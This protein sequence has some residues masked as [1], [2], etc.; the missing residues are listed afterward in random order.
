M[1]GN[2]KI[3]EF[4]LSSLL[5]R[6]VKNLSIA[7]VL[8]LVISVLASV[9]FLTRS[10]KLE[11]AALLADSPELIV[12]K[13]VGGRH[14]LIPVSRAEAISS[15]TGVGKVKPRIWGY[16][17]DA[18]ADANYTVMALDEESEKKFA[19]LE[20][21]MPSGK[22]ECALGR[23]VA[24]ARG[25]KVGR[26][27]VLRGGVDGRVFSF[28][29]TGIFS[30]QSSL[31]TNDLIV[32]GREDASLLLGIP[33]GLAT[34]LV[35]SV[36]NELEVPTIAAKIKNSLFY[37]C[38]PITRDEILRTYETVFDWRGGAALT[39]FLGAVLAFCILAYDRASGLSAEEKREI[40]ILKAIGWDASDV[41]ELKFW[42]GLAVSMTACLAGL[43]LAYVHVYFFGAALFRPIFAG[44]STLFPAIRLQPHID[45]FQIA[46]LLFV[47]I[48]PYSACSIVPCWK[49][50]V[51]DPDYVMR[52]F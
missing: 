21:R 23:G 32:A 35:V 27:L 34:D 13:I 44:W 24:E 52:E 41:L 36:Y 48:V 7:A 11:A 43:I 26:T 22:M 33:D 29:V 20:G 30:A 39:V 31:L 3:L 47:T 40:G 12:Q 17:Y 45:F 8:A 18:N 5:R 2:R 38:R 28:E 42:E 49:T 6:R 37:D 46:G 1:T 14:D 4:A 50:A 9:L 15:I 51:T 10:F 16:H 19:M 25:M